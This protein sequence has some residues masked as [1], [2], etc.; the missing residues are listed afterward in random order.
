MKILICNPSTTPLK[1]TLGASKALIELAEELEQLGWKYK[2]ACSSDVGYSSENKQFNRRDYS[3]KLREYLHH[4]ATDYNVV[5]YDHEDLPYPRNEFSPKT[6]F[7]AYTAILIFHLENILIPQSRKWK[8]KIRSLIRGHIDKKIFHQ[9]IQR[10]Y[11]TVKEADLIQVLNYDDKAELVRRGV[12]EEKIILTPNGISRER[13]ALFD[14]VTS[15]LPPCPKVVFVGTFDYRKGAIEFPIIVQNICNEIPE[16]SFRL[17]GTTGLF[18]TKEQVLA[19]FPKELRSRIE[20]IDQFLPEDLPG[21]LAPCSVGLFPSYLEGFPF[22]VLE[23]LAASIPVIAYNSPGL[24]MM[25]P[26]EYLVTP[27]DSKSMSEKIVILLKDKHKLATARVWAKQQ[28]QQFCWKKISAQLS[29]RY[30]DFL[31]KLQF[32]K[33]L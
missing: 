21:L 4:H 15:D 5:L 30:L 23:M 31:H 14:A 1:K 18:R 25:L 7:V 27:G 11:L 8:S 33:S 12:S 32:S 28:S 24:P 26:T 13:R 3:Q 2:L 16:V 22:G 29:S 17:L 20:V 9:K 10:S 6:L 19:H